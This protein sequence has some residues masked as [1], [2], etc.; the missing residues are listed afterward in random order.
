MSKK[1]KAEI[2]MFMA[3]IPAL[4][5]HVEVNGQK[6]IEKVYYV[7]L[8]GETIT[9]QSGKL[10][11]PKDRPEIGVTNFPNGDRFPKGKTVLVTGIR[12]LAEVTAG[13]TVKTAEWKSEVPAV[14][15]NGELKVRQG[16]TLTE[17]PNTAI[18]NFKG[19]PTTSEDDFR[20]VVPFIFREE[21]PFELMA[22][23]AGILPANTL[24]RYE[25][26]CIE[27]ENAAVLS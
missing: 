23:F 3:S 1:T 12:L 22:E 11:L 21:T 24:L 7:A 26:S 20:E 2:L 17:L 15:K 16:A 10:V 6:A 4:S 27:M 25:F 18:A 19:V 13:K 5:S 8:P 9:T 14:V